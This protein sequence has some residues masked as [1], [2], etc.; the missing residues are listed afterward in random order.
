[1]IR[2]IFTEGI[3]LKQFGTGFE[4]KP[5]LRDQMEIVTKCDI[6]IDAGRHSGAKVKH[7]D[8]SRDIHASV[9]ASLVEMGIE[10]IDL[11]LIHRP[12]RS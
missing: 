10:Y 4:E 2:Q 3:L 6:V 7:Y 12:D 9:D 8:T 11:L 1:M 5:A